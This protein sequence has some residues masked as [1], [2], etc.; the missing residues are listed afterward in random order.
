MPSPFLTYFTLS[1]SCIPRKIWPQ[2]KYLANVIASAPIR[3]PGRDGHMV[4]FGPP[5]LAK[6]LFAEVDYFSSVI[7]SLDFK[8]FCRLPSFPKRHFQ[9]SN[10]LI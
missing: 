8:A 6:D 3:I 1:V 9:V 10:F 7:S 4:N 5:I 2:L